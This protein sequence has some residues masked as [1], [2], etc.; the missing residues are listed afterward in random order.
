[1]VKKN[2]DSFTK[3]IMNIPPRSPLFTTPHALKR[4]IQLILIVSG[5]A[6]AFDAFTIRF[7]GFG[8]QKFLALTPQAATHGFIWQFIT[9]LFLIPSPLFTFSFMLDVAFSML[10][11]WFIGTLLFERIGSKKFLIGYAFSGIVSGIFALLAMF[12]LGEYRLISTC[13]PAI[14]AVVNMW[15]MADPNQQVIL[16][17]ILP[18]K[19]KW[20]LLFA[21]LGTIVVNFL[22]QD[23]VMASTYLAAFIASYLY[24]LAALHFRSPFDWMLGFDKIFK[25]STYRLHSFWQWYIAAPFRK[26]TAGWNRLLQKRREKEARFLDNTLEKIS[27]F[28]KGSLTI[29][30]KLR[31]RWISFKKKCF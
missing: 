7:F 2:K 26:I 23:L 27:K 17:F 24:G 1:M 19:A 12:A 25:K 10:I 9:S 30:E 11:L 31:L 29:Y 16:F 13:F 15:V 8:L 21:L 22:Q 6:V 20:V 5:I 28:G 14:F 4:L 18:I 3:H